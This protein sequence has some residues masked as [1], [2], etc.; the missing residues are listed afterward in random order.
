MADE[1]KGISREIRENIASGQSSGVGLRGLRE[2]IRQFGGRLEVQSGQVG[3]CIISVLPAPNPAFPMKEDNAEAGPEPESVHV[4]SD[5]IA[6]SPVPEAATILCIDDE[7]NGLLPRRL[8]LESA[9]YRV[10]EARSGAEGIQLF[11]SEKV[12]VVILDYWMSGMKGTTVAAE[13]TVGTARRRHSTSRWN[14]FAAA[15]PKNRSESC[16]V[17]ICSEFGEK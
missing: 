1:G 10:I 3:A 8:L 4:H 15:T 13:L 7:A 12:D 16:G 5:P 17:A 6:E 2:R 14:W 9:G 11:G